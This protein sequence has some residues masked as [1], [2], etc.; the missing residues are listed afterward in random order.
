MKI[1]GSLSTAEKFSDSATVPWFEAPSPMN[2]SA[3]PPVPSVFCVSAA[4]T[5]IG[6]APPTIAFAPSMPLRRS[7]MCI[8]PPLPWQSPP[9]LQ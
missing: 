3:T 6:G 2:A 5:A 7:A 4:P 1:I 8:E 9:C